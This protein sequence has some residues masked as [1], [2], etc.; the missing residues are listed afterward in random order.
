[1]SVR[2]CG[3]EDLA[4]LVPIYAHYV[5]SSTATFEE[6]PPALSDWQGRLAEVRALGLPFLVA[7]LD[8]GVVGYAYANRWKARSAYR[9]TVED[10]VYVG[11]GVQGRGIGTALLRA[12][13]EGCATAGI[14][15]VIAVVGGDDPAASLALHRGCG[16]RPA[17]RLLRVG[18]KHGRWLDTRLLQCSLATPGQ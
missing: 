6:E 2:A 13:L 3:P 18:F 5:T 17:G 14:R 4:T 1:M 9:Y 7:E 16:F 15:E 11:P 10:S 8:G 12:L